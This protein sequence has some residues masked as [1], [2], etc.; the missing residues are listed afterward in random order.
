MKFPL[1][2]KVSHICFHRGYRKLFSP[3]LDHELNLPER[4]R[5]EAHL[6]KCSQ[7]R[8]ELD[9]MSFAAHMVRQVGIPLPLQTRI[10]LWRQPPAEAAQPALRHRGWIP[11]AVTATI[12]LVVSWGLV[13]R[14]HQP[15]G[16]PALG[17]YEVQALE[18]APRINS[19]HMGHKGRLG[20]GQGVETDDHSRA[21][22]TVGK[23][24]SVELAPNSRLRLV[25]TSP[26]EH[27]LALDQG[28]LQ[29]RILAPPRLFF[30][31]TPSAVAIDLGCAYTLEVDADGSSLLHVTS[32]RV[33]LWLNGHESMVPAGASCRS[34][35]GTGPGTPFLE[36]A[37]AVFRQALDRFDFQGRKPADLAA[38]LTEARTADSLTLWHLL[39]QVQGGEREQVFQR[40]AGFIPPPATVTKEGALNLNQAM[41]D[42]WKVA[43]DEKVTE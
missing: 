16:R 15:S 13:H 28:R 4:L 23:I 39:Y 1:F 8:T 27:R 30:V 11:L 9:E 38:L 40:L 14:V 34:R 29:A 7:C 2:Q 5:L 32:G 19:H 12:L 20:T 17:F 6:K 10:P 43:I 24:G 35:K 26:Q 33:A 37:S 18:G 22:I 25:E 31:D 36:S 42:A 41:L 3:F 21:R